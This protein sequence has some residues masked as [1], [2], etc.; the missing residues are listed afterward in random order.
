MNPTA[1]SAFDRDFIAAIQK[2]W[3]PVRRDRDGLPWRTTRDPWLTLMAEFM[4]AQTQVSRVAERYVE[5]AERFPT[6]RACARTTQAEVVTRWNGLG[7]NRRAVSLHQCA[8]II[9]DV[10][11]GSVPSELNE[12]L[13]LPGVGPYIARAVLSLAFERNV[14]VVDINIKRVISRA[15]IGTEVSDKMAQKVADELVQSLPSRE[16]NLALM[17]FGSTVCRARSPLCEVCPLSEG[18]CTW[19]QRRRES[20]AEIPDPAVSL[21]NRAKGHSDFAGSDRQGRGRLVRRACLGPIA[22]ADVALFAGWPEDAQ[23]ALRIVE[24]LVD[25]GLFVRTPTGSYQLA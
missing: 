4:L 5:M 15:V 13:A 9:C 10:H 20:V 21:G 8:N 22:F 24:K 11:G 12:L 18:I 6:A 23:R 1:R 25:E 16:W 19:Q 2:W 14:G 3:P 7:Y 17:D